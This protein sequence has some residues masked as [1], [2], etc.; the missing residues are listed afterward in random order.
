L[1]ELPPTHEDYE[2]SLGPPSNM[3][4]RRMISTRTE[5]GFGVF[6]LVFAI[7]FYSR[8]STTPVD[9]IV[10]YQIVSYIYAQYGTILRSTQFEMRR[11]F[12]YNC[13]VDSAIHKLVS[14]SCI[15]SV[16]NDAYR[17]TESGLWQYDASIAPKIIRCNS[18]LVPVLSDLK[19]TLR[20]LDACLFESADMVH[21]TSKEGSANKEVK[22]FDGTTGNS[23]PC[24]GLRTPTPH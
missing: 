24:C 15:E 1:M 12:I 5:S 16:E 17:I 6:D 9:R 4:S 10:C 3:R 18:V 20:K 23:C 19:L 8:H 14:L 11:N 21:F 2:S 13:E 22:E 7:F